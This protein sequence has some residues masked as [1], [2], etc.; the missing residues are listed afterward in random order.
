[1]PALSS[2]LAHYDAT[3]SPRLW[4]ALIQA[5]RDFFGQHGFARTDRPGVFHLSPHDGTKGGEAP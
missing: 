2:A 1:V 5:Q 4:T 3:R